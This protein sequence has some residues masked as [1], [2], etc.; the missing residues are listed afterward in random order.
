VKQP[1]TQ[2]D[3]SINV[4]GTSVRCLPVPAREQYQVSTLCVPQPVPVPFGSHRLIYVWVHVAPL[5]EGSL[6]RKTLTSLIP[7]ARLGR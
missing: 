2:A 3:V 1:H 4:P 7:P 6:G 5:S